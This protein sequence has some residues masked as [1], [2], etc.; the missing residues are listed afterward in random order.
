MM[1]RLEIAGEKN[2]PA[3]AQQVVVLRDTLLRTYEIMSHVIVACVTVIRF[4]ALLKHRSVQSL[5]LHTRS[6]L[7][8]R[9]ARSLSFQ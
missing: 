8:R 6:E 4:T 7:Q 3:D 2:C 5:Q 1:G 9:E